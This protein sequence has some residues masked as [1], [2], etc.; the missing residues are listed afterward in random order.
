MRFVDCW[1]EMLAEYARALAEHRGALLVE[2][3]A[4]DAVVAFEER[5]E[6]RPAERRLARRAGVLELAAPDDAQRRALAERDADVREQRRVV[7]AVVRP[8]VVRRRPRRAQ[9]VVGRPAVP[10]TEPLPCTVPNDPPSNTPDT[11]SWPSRLSAR[12]W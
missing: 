10:D 7:V 1:F 4:E 11:C 12:F 3:D 2:R 6:V 8:L 9:D 5:V